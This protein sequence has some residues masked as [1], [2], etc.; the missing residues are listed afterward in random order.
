MSAAVPAPTKLLL[1]DDLDE[2]LL[3]LEALLC[4]DDLILLKARSGTDALELLLLHDVALALVDVQMPDMDGFELAEL[5]RGSERTRSVPIIFVT[6]GAREGSRIFQGYDAGAVDFLFKPIDPHILRH[7][8]ETFVSL[9][10]QRQQLAEQVEIIRASEEMRR[11]IIESSEDMI[12]VVDLTAQ[13]TSLNAKGKELFGAGGTDFVR[14][15]ALWADDA[16]AERAFESARSGQTARFQS[17]GGLSDFSGCHWDVVVSPIRDA[18]GRVEKVL[19]VAR[20]VTELHRLNDELAATLRLNETFVAA[21]GHDLRTPLNNVVMSAELLLSRASPGDLR[22]IERL[23]GSAQRMSRMIDELFDLARARLSGGIPV[24]PEPNVDLLPLAEKIVAEL[25][26]DAHGRAIQLQAAGDIRGTW[27]GDRMG[28][29][30]SNL[31]GNALRHGSTDAPIRLHLDGTHPFEVVL[32]VSN[33]GQIPEEV[34]S[35]LFQPFRRGTTRR[36][37]VEGLGLGLF[38]V[39]QIVRAHAGRITAESAA[40]TT[41]FRVV[42]PRQLDATPERATTN[43]QPY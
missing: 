23:R 5:M 20:D 24:K 27:D 21:I 41:S 12:A 28:Q 42:L 4:R 18:R 16:E 39:E 43:S 7:K 19:G 36:S 10:K 31:L 30:L 35:C 32:T 8:V 13:V 14:W 3:A 6:A 38:I 25:T 29:V 33:G 40:G 15:S 2:N 1:V 9:H 26:P 34:L 22:V 37:S 11:R 17:R